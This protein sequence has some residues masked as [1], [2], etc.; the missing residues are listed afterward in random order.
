MPTTTEGDDTPS[1]MYYS[2]FY[3]DG[4]ELIETLFHHEET[5]PIWVRI[6]DNLKAGAARIKND[7]PLATSQQNQTAESQ[8]RIQ[9]WIQHVDRVE[10][11][12]GV[13]VPSIVMTRDEFR[14]AVG[15]DVNEG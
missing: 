2:T 14:Q 11:V 7:F 15:S 10:T 8:Q 4:D 5:G 1:T 3:R 6:V 9:T 13:L 12:F